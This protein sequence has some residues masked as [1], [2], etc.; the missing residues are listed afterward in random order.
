M[1]LAALPPEQRRIVGIDTEVTFWLLLLANG[2]IALGEVQ[3][4]LAVMEPED[5]ELYRARLKHWQ[6]EFR[7]SVRQ[8]I[9]DKTWQRMV[10]KFRGK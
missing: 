2:C 8:D 9:E 4:K 10:A 7:N 6:P 1:N 3:S 5:A